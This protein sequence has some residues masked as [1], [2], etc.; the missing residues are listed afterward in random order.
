MKTT[1]MTMFGSLAIAAMLLG[2][3]GENQTD[4][5]Q[6]TVGQ[7]SQALDV[8]LPLTPFDDMV[9]PYSTRW[10]SI[11]K[12]GSEYEYYIGHA[13]ASWIDFNQVWVVF[14]TTGTT[15]TDGYEMNIDRMRFFTSFGYNLYPYFR[16]VS[17]GADCP[18]N[19]TPSQA[20]ALATFPIPPQRPR[21]TRFQNTYEV[22]DCTAP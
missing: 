14:A 18:V 2:C 7:I 9:K 17:P 16:E 6:P 8:D 19:P 5:E 21:R 1:C 10:R 3:G 13:P 15:P 20:N 4:E 11:I 12:S 22:R